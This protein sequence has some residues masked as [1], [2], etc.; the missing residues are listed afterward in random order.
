M[1]KKQNQSRI[2]RILLALLVALSLAT[3]MQPR[4]SVFAANADVTSTI[5]TSAD[6]QSNV[7]NGVTLQC[8]NW[9]YNN[10][11][12]NMDTIAKLGYS[13][14]QTSPIQQAKESTVGLT[15]GNRWWM[16]YQPATFT[17]DNTG[18]SALGTKSEFEAM[19]AKAHEDGVKV[20]VDVVANH[21]GNQTSNNLSTSIPSDLRD[22]SSCWHNISVNI[23]DYSNRYNIT[24]YCMGGLPDLNTAS[25]KVQG[26][27]LTYLKECIDAGADGFRFDAAKHIET[28]QDSSSGCGSDF[29][30]NVVDAA[31]TYASS[32][33]G[34]SLYCYGEILDQ[35]DLS[36]TLPISAY[37]QYIS[38]TDNNQGNNLRNYVNNGNASAAGSSSYCKSTTADKLVLWAE[39]HD[40]WANNESSGVSTA[41]IN[42]AWALVAARNAAMG[43]YFARPNS[44]GTILGTADT[45]GWS[46]SEVG[47]VNIFHNVFAGQTEY[48]ASE[49]N[50][51]Y[52]E[53][54]TS[55]AILVNCSGTNAD[56]SVTAHK[57]AAGTY[58]DQIS[59]NTFTVANG[60]ISGSIGSTGIAVVYNT[61]A[62]VDP[63]TSSSTVTTTSNVAYLKLPSGWSTP[64]YCYVYSGSN[65]SNRNAAW[66]GVAMTK[67]S[68]GV[69]KYAVSDSITSPKV[70]FTDGKTQ[71]PASGQAG[72]SLTGNMIYA[73]G[74]WGNYTA[75]AGDS[76]SAASSAS[77]VTETRTA[78][79][80]KPS[81]W[82]STLYCYVYSADD[83]S[84]R[85]AAWPGIAMT[86]VSGSVYK[87]Q[88]SDSI[89]NPRVM[90]TDGSNQY[91]SSGQAGLTM[92]SDS[93][94]YQNGSWSTY[95]G[96]VTTS[97][98]AYIDKP[99]G[100]GSTIYCYVYSK[101]N[102]SNRNAAWPGVAMTNVSGSIYKYEVSDSISDP[103]VI[104]TDGTN[105]YPGSMQSGV[106]L[107]GSMIYQNGTWNNY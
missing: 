1:K 73:D 92:T 103:L 18:N 84:N 77:T 25:S 85:N 80:S 95:S 44:T 71:Y 102:E 60:K 38:V 11:K 5:A 58:T 104:F 24:Q 36:G 42:K 93:M 21:M 89:T 46:Y 101:S 2:A 107:T 26:Y 69:Y 20:I 105:Q 16:Y 34:I 81:G 49:G 27:V 4:L 15:V 106:T 86:N 90:F 74:S 51:A 82:G 31:K 62:I 40:T 63:G 41:N 59:G 37:T 94:I 100:W 8:W 17:I 39:S 14:I 83:E 19:C 78:Y 66:P 67:V 47:K 3:C 96:T 72:L 29:W 70:M 55:G 32:S 48:M 88:I 28:P 99:S 43:L 9:S 57:M 50:I 91:P 30:P 56:I 87:Y 61:K 12:A 22:D 79:L 10:I 75:V 45:T 76:S 52:C 7:Q 13:A 53:R 65:A 68:D 6:L 54:G 23:S 35:P 33:R 64:V 98:I 97:N